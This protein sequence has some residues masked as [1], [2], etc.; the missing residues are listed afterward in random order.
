[1]AYSLVRFVVNM[2]A[3]AKVMKS[4]KK[5]GID[6]G[7]VTI[8]MGTANNHL[9]ELL[10]I[11]ETRK[12][13]VSIIVDSEVAGDALRGISEELSFKKPNHGI[14]FSHRLS[15]LHGCENLARVGCDPDNRRSSMYKVI[16]AVV[17]KGRAEDV[18]EA[19]NSAGARGGTIINA[20]G[21]GSHE[22]R[23]FFSMEIEPE[24][25]TVFIIAEESMKDDIVRSIR[26]ALDLDEPDNGVVF[27][28]DA[29]EVYGLH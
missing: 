24:R 5:Y 15:E 17:D 22:V 11:D 16:Y 27:V 2:G 18:M 12:E 19:A 13:I 28:L 25:E 10:A 8:G 23:K 3:A 20:R 26:D 14:A 4:A 29:E 9:L 7:Y 6:S 1:M 21:A